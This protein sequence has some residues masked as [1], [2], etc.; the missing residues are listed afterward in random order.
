MPDN[1]RQYLEHTPDQIRNWANTIGQSTE[2]FVEYILDNH[3]EKKALTI[4]LSFKNLTK[5]YSD[6]LIEKSCETLM[7]ISQAP[8][9]SVLKTILKCM[10]DSQKAKENGTLNEAKTNTDYGFVRGAK[11]FGGVKNEE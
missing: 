8:T 7:T 3:V 5:Y 10:K 6:E 2:K 9:L 1:H 11:Y 4:L